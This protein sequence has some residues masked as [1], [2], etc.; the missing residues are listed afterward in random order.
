MDTPE[1]SSSQ[2]ALDSLRTVEFRQT[3]RGY[4]IDDVD[5]YLERVAVEAE[6]LQEQHRQTVERL[7]QAAERIQSL[8]QQLLAVQQAA[9]EG[10]A[11]PAVEAAAA[12]PAPV[13]AAEPTAAVS[14]DTLQKTLLLAQRFVEQTKAEAEAQARQ[15]VAEAEDRAR[16]ISEEA[17]RHVRE[18]VSRLESLRVQLSGEVERLASHLE[19]E[20][21]RLRTSL[22]DLMGWL[23]DLRPPAAPAQL[24]PADAPTEA[25]AAVQQPPD[26]GFSG[27]DSGE[28]SRR[29][30][31]LT[32]AYDRNG[33]GR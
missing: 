5:D 18:D 30:G 32:G 17:E 10:R 16:A 8:E 2:S 14:D 27:G 11:E 1:S 33:D 7:R 3:L 29:P 4:H 6:A 31:A 12:V 13:A 22:A 9:A 19:A 15:L 20:R 24:P 23:D 28:A 25:L 26:E 21:N